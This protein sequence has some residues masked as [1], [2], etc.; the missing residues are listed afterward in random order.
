[1]S[2]RKVLKPRPEVEVGDLWRLP[3]A[4][5]IRWRRTVRVVRVEA[6]YVVVEMLNEG[7][8]PRDAFERLGERMPKGD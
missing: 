2:E 4:E 5:R 8:M 6:E 1:M 3:E 7:S